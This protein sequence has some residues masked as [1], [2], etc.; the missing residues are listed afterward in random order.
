[1]WQLGSTTTTTLAFPLWLLYSVIPLVALFW[2]VR[3]V[4][5]LCGWKDHTGEEPWSV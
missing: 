5:E 1:L 3:I 2:I 4:A